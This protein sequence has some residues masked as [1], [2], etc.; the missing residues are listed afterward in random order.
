MYTIDLKKWL[1]TDNGSE[2]EGTPLL[3]LYG[4]KY[5]KMAARERILLDSYKQI[6][7]I[8]ET[9]GDLEQY[10]LNIDNSGKPYYDKIPYLGFSEKKGG[11][12]QTHLTCGYLEYTNADDANPRLYIKFYDKIDGNPFKGNF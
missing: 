2:T 5:N 9:V 3:R 1:P 11:G 4:V 8:I 10:G 7:P 12:T 6:R